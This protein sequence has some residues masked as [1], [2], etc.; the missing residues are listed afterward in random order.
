MRHEF[1]MSV[2]ADPGGVGRV[3]TAFAEFAGTC[4]LPEDVRRSLN[5]A[6]DE[7]LANVISHGIS[8]REGGSVTVEAQLDTAQV[9][10][11]ISDDGPAFDPLEEETPDT[12]LSIEEREIGGLG[13]HLVRKL[14]DKV[15]YERRDGQNV[16]M[17]SK[18]LVAGTR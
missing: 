10:V 6:L 8:E 2:G 11:S 17:L 9:N 7:L 1:R 13:I 5:I 3:N 14:M 4:G 18:K 12:T 16:V 15:S